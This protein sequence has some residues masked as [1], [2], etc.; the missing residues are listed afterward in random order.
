VDYASNRLIAQYSDLNFTH[1][2]ALFF[3]Y[4]LSPLFTEWRTTDRRELEFPSLPPDSYRLD[5]EVRDPWGNWSTE[6]AAFQFDVRGPWFRSWW[7]LTLC[8]AAAIALFALF[9]RIR[10]MVHWKREVELVGLVE[11]RTADLKKA[12]E[13]LV[14]LSAT[15]GLTGV[16]NRRAF[17]Q[18]LAREWSRFQRTA[19][20]LSMLLL[21]V[22]HFKILNDTEGHQHGDHCL[23][24]LAAE[25]R[26]AARREI[27]L[28]A[29]YGGEE[30]AIV[31]PATGA[32]AAM[33][34]AERI[35]QSVA[36]LWLSNSASPVA[37]FLTV[38]IGAGTAHPGMHGG[39][40]EFLASIDRAL[41]SA[42]HAGRNRV[43]FFDKTECEPAK[44]E[45]AETLPTV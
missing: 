19:E 4:R 6:A 39:K 5:V 26:R 23:A 20:P 28:V 42:K 40:E 13:E 24:Q 34:L 44:A 27:D 17:D 36:G 38:S 3:R 31:L 33:Q 15:D 18:T 45:R 7:F 32:D 41:Y 35:R 9:I 8:A 25:L 43:A 16:A 12:N 37:P 29:R 2:N 11:Q 10:I 1:G 14:R 30:F 21:D 22:D